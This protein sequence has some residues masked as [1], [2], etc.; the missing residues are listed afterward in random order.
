MQ[1][2]E[3]TAADL[4][5]PTTDRQILTTDRQIL[6]TDRQILATF[7]ILTMDVKLYLCLIMPLMNETSQ[8]AFVRTCKTLYEYYE[9]FYKG[10]TV[11]LYTPLNKDPS[12]FS[13]TQKLFCQNGFMRLKHTPMSGFQS[14]KCPIKAL[15]LDEALEVPIGFSCASI[16]DLIIISSEEK[17]ILD[18]YYK[19]DS[20]LEGY[21]PEKPLFE[22][23]SNLK[24][25]V[26]SISF[27]ENFSNLKS[28]VFKDVSFSNDT[29]SMF[30]RFISL[31]L[32][33]LDGCD[34]RN[35]DM[36]EMFVNCTTLTTLRLKSNLEKCTL[37]LPAQLKMLS[38]Y[39]YRP[40][41]LD[42][43]RCTQIMG[44]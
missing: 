41:E 1:N 36:S 13:I 7:T 10:Q 44:L 12:L 39:Y 8:L 32:I 33:H 29:G 15:Y 18:D 30:S 40:L 23:F 31:E 14:D 28:L 34:L 3:R 25:L 22:F 2:M 5:I 17:S 19:G 38:L 11:S 24:P 4:Q 21:L 27:F 26:S 20:S 43:S 42:I 37:S 9:E 6:T 16:S 35:C